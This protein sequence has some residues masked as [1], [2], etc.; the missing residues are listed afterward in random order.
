M[1][2]KVTLM[3][4]INK[5]KLLAVTAALFFTTWGAQTASADTVTY[6]HFDWIGDTIHINNPRNVTG[7]AGQITL[8]GVVSNPPG[9]PSTIVA[10]C[11]DIMHD[12]QQGGSYT[13]GGALSGTPPG[14]SGWNKIGGLMLER[15][16]Y[17]AQGLLT[18]HIDGHDYS[19]QDVSAATQV[20]IW[21]A[22]YGPIP[23]ATGFYYDKINGS[24]PSNDFKNLVN[25]LTDNAALGVSYNT[26]NAA[27]G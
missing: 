6:A 23:P 16:N 4:T 20:A 24:N 5:K 7:G 8:T 12:L 21:A 14:G 17:L 1:H 19:R 15:N 13:V 18:Y 10:W 26:L 22:E 2:W 9:F 25:F 11:L 27:E 3:S